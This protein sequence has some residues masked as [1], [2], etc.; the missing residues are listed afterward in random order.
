MKTLYDVV[1]LTIFAG[2]IV[3]FLQRSTSS[4]ADDDAPL[5]Q[6]LGAGAGC[7]AA[8]YFGN[9]GQDAIGIA[10]IVGTV[11]FIFF[12]LKPFGFLPRP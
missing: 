5:W 9:H 12:F 8:N 1:T 4:E 7:G 3:L 6:Y 11:G 10:L 2:L